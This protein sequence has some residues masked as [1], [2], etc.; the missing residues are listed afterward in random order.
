MLRFN[1]SLGFF[2][3]ALAG[4]SAFSVMPLWASEPP[5]WTGQQQQQEAG[6][7]KRHEKIKD[8][9]KKDKVPSHGKNDSASSGEKVQQ[10]RSPAQATPS[11]QPT[12]DPEPDSAL[13][14]IP[15]KRNAA[16][17]PLPGTNQVYRQTLEKLS[18]PI[19]F[20]VL[21]RPL[22][23]VLNEVARLAGLRMRIN[24]RADDINVS[25]RRFTG[26][27][28]T[29]LDDLAR[30]H[31]MVWF[32]ERDLI[33]VAK[34]DTSTIKTFQIPGLSDAKLRDAL[35]RYG[36]VNADFAVEVDE[37]SATARVFGPPRLVSRIESIISSL[38]PAMTEASD[39]P[40]EII[41]YGQRGAQ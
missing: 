34:A 5:G 31:N 12:Q 24:D 7:S 9:E 13:S 14:P 6:T 21:E 23:A 33:D 32:A 35:Q 38:R 19:D 25:S 41:R 15:Q 30:I 39:G 27:V 20:F 3:I 16:D 29:A 22:D 18:L 10:S 1:A 28:R 2:V 4:F 17:E 36:L 40:V 37:R 26:T 11:Q 8:H